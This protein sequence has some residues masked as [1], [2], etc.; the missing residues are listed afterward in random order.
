[1]KITLKHAFQDL[2]FNGYLWQSEEYKKIYDWNIFYEHFTYRS[3][4]RKVFNL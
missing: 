3:N 1:M 2:H 4:A